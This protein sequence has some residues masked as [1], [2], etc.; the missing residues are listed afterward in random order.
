ML[1]IEANQVEIL[2]QQK[3]ILSYLRGGASRVIERF[4]YLMVF[5]EYVASFVDVGSFVLNNDIL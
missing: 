2:Q 3:E 1:G 5:F 4:L